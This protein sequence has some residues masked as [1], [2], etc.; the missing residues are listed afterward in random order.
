MKSSWSWTN[1]CY[2]INKELTKELVKESSKEM[3]AFDSND[4]RIFCSRKM[5]S[6]MGSEY[7]A[8][9]FSHQDKFRHPQRGIFRVSFSD[10][11]MYRIVKELIENNKTESKSHFKIKLEFSARWATNTENELFIFE[12]FLKYV[13]NYCITHSL[14]LKIHRKIPPRVCEKDLLSREHLYQVY[15]PKNLIQMSI[16]DTEKPFRMFWSCEFDGCNEIIKKLIVP[17]QTELGIWL[18]QEDLWNIQ[19][20]TTSR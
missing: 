11:L 19:S 17:R 2:R 8:W 12:F 20:H 6:I 14:C 18:S 9:A 13:R 1:W 4:S 15:I 3:K 7:N 16:I 10:K 5:L